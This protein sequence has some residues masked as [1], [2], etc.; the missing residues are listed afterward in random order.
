[1]AKRQIVFTQGSYYHVYNRGANRE[2]IFRSD[3]NYLFLQQRIMENVNEWDV[4]VIAYCLMPNHYHIVLRQDGARSLSNFLQA[5]FNS[6]TKA[7]NKMYNRS[8]TLFEGRFRA[9]PILKEEYLIHLCRYIHRNPLEA[10]LVANLNY[11]P[12][13]NYLEWIG[14]RSGPLV[15]REFV[16][17]RFP[18]SEAY[19]K[20]VLEY[21]PKTHLER[22]IRAL[23][24]E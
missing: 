11:W 17:S 13:S 9:I 16:S 4:T 8:G 1:M 15:D 10:H 19:A 3:D 23:S 2:P 21:T 22:L 6:Y 5:L 20:F 12:Y 14:E 24:F 18:A 7:F